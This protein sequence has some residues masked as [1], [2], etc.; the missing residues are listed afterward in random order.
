MTL[1]LLDLIF[2]SKLMEQQIRSA[3]AGATSGG[4]SLLPHLV[5]N[6][7][8]TIEPQ[9][10][11]FFPVSDEVDVINEDEGVVVCADV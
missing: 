9:C 1:E 4:A 7:A 10:I 2:V 6:L 11:H 5:Q 3:V 8:S